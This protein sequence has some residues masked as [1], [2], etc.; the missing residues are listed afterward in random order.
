MKA[1]MH[2]TIEAS[3][4]LFLNSVAQRLG[5]SVRLLNENK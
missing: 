5:L 4:G 3:F 1:V 2:E